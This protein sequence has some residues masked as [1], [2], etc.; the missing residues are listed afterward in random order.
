VYTYTH[1]YN[2]S[3]MCI[4]SIY[5]PTHSHTTTVHIT[6]RRGTRDD[7]RCVRIVHA[8][9]SMSRSQ[10]MSVRSI[11]RNTTTCLILHLN[12][13]HIAWK[14][15]M[16]CLKDY[17]SLCIIMLQMWTIFCRTISFTFRQIFFTQRAFKIL[18]RFTWTRNDQMILRLLRK[19]MDHK[20][21]NF[22]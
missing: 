16:F 6:T 17:I 1:Y 14:T 8:G 4:T 15:I 22:R 12:W 19:M 7:S 5:T 2:A 3:I 13:F 10:F 18:T 21:D 9:S 11:A 20:T